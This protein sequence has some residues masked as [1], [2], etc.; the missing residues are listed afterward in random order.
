MLLRVC[1]ARSNPE[2]DGRDVDITWRE[3]CPTVSYPVSPLSPQEEANDSEKGIYAF[4]RVN[5]LSTLLL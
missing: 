3:I 5:S 4:V 2:G 1:I